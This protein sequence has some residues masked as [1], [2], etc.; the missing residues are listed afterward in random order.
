MRSRG[1]ILADARISSG[2][3]RLGSTE[4]TTFREDVQ[5]SEPR[6]VRQLA[7]RTPTSRAL[8][9]DDPGVRGFRRGGE[10]RPPSPG[11]GKPRSDFTRFRGDGSFARSLDPRAPRSLRDPCPFRPTST[12]SFPGGVS[13]SGAGESGG[14]EA[15]RAARRLLTTCALRQH[16]AHASGAARGGASTWR[17]WKE[18]AV[19]VRQG[20]MA[21]QGSARTT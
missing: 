10:S 9:T 1:A 20:S 14:G 16:H 5:E 12:S 13:S 8:R 2:E 17:R 15:A 6:S 19:S 18:I 21:R 4:R 7:R 11:D 3:R